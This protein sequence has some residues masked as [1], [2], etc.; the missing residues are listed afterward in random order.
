MALPL[1]E[2]RQHLMPIHLTSAA[3][4]DK[5]G[6][7]ARNGII[8]LRC[9]SCQTSVSCCEYESVCKAAYRHALRSSPL[10]GTHKGHHCQ[11]GVRIW[12]GDFTRC[13][14]GLT[15]LLDPSSQ[16]PGVF[17]PRGRGQAGAPAAAQRRGRTSSTPT[18]GWRC[19]KARKG[20]VA[21]GLSGAACVFPVRGWRSGLTSTHPV[22]RQRAGGCHD[23]VSGTGLL[24]HEIERGLATG[25]CRKGERTRGFGDPPV[26]RPPQRRAGT[27]TGGLHL[28]EQV[29][30]AGQQ[31][32][33]DRDGGDV[34][35][36]LFDRKS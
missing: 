18:S 10:F 15:V 29:P 8:M 17:S 2:F 9:N 14:A 12:P 5:F 25:S 7:L 30:G 26:S 33:G 6:R 27:G 3:V 22:P 13:R 23:H 28:V 4:R 19:S 32:A 16:L 24:S 20:S 34:L 11:E 35:P 31:L 21:V 36:A 1:K